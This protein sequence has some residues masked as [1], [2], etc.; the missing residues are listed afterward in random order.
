MAFVTASDTAVFTSLSS[1]IVG[2]SGRRNALIVSRAKPSF[3][4]T[5]RK[6]TLISLTMLICSPS[7]PRF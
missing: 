5:D 1:D 6:S 3:S 7:F 4:G 2:F